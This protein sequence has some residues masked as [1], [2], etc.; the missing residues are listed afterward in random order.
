MSEPRPSFDLQSHSLHSDGELSPCEVVAAAAAASVE[1]LALTD[2]DSVEG[3]GEALEEAAA[4]DLRL[5]PAVE[6]STADAGAPDLHILGYLINHRDRTLSDWLRN[7]RASREQRA[8]RWPAR[9]GSS[10]TSSTSSRC[11][12][13]Q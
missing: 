3:I 12:R 13:E 5:V 4:H 2:H 1:L 9:S 8:W 10:A 11:A 7:S 6:I